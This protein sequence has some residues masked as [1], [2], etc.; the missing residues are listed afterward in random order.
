[1]YCPYYQNSD[2]FIP[3]AKGLELWKKTRK[4][5]SENKPG[6]FETIEYAKDQIWSIA[7]ILIEMS[8]LYF[9]FQGAYKTY[10]QNGNI[11]VV[12][13]AIIAVFLFIAFD[14]IGIMLH[15]HD[16]AQRTIDAASYVVHPDAN[17][18][19]ELHNRLKETTMREFFGML[20]LS[21]SAV[22]KI[23][24]L[25]YFFQLSNYSILVVFTLLYLIVVYIHAVHTVYWWPAFK[26]KNRI[27]KQYNEWITLFDK[28][29][30]TPPQNTIISTNPIR[31][32]FQSSSSILMNTI[33]TCDNDR[34]KVIPISSG[35]YL[36][37]VTGP[38]WDE[39][40]VSLCSQWGDR[41]VNDLLNSCIKVQL[42]QCGIIIP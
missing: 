15:G 25:W 9:T 2:K 38:L 41:G 11:G 34:I 7:S 42:N 28:G 29:L 36:L 39:N 30:P 4:N 26:L 14:I 37:E 12:W 21:I 33:A 20:L 31:H 27:K 40:I 22:L 17:V 10:Q 6:V 24:A 23:A 16:K 13:A 1:M 35:N 8:A 5:K 18:R 19:L 3:D 32:K